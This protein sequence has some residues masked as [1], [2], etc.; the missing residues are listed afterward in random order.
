MAAI[1]TIADYM[2]F[3]GQSTLANQTQVAEAIRQATAY[4][5]NVCGRTFALAAMGNSHVWTFDGKGGLKLFTPQAPIIS[6]T[7]VETWNGTA[8]EVVDAVSYTPT[9]GDDGEYICFREQY[10]WV[11][12]ILNWRVT[13]TYGF[14]TIPADLKRAILLIAHAFARVSLRAPDLKSQSDGDQAFVYNDRMTSDIPTDA[15]DLLAPYK[16]FV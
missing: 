7:S 2:T 3:T 16:R 15:L 4:A 6:V 9:I 14:T 8:W 13:Y 12:G 11:V 1:V 10:T 5:E